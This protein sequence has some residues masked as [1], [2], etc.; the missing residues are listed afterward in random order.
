MTAHDDLL[1]AWIAWDAAPT[2]PH[3]AAR[4]IDA[5]NALAVGL[6]VSPVWVQRRQAAG[7]R[8]GLT[9]DTILDRIAS[10]AR[11]AA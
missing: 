11:S 6:G 3:T 7:R 8:A 4:H 1:D 5:R 10:D 9:H 2:S